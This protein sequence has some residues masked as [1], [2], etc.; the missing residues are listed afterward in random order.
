MVPRGVRNA[1]PGNI[2]RSAIAWQGE[3]PRQPDPDFVTFT[4]PE[5]GL[6]AIARILTTYQASGFTT[7]RQ[8]ISRWAPVN[9]NDTSAYID[10]VT[11][12]VGADADEVL[13]VSSPP[14]MEAM[15]RAI[16][17]HE[18]GE[19]PYSDDTYRLALRLAGLI[20]A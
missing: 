18:N 19:Q 9:E 3:A 12:E 7:I 13:D 11:Q 15:V 20:A 1:N 4:G 17:Q 8:I 2:R 5:W 16:V 6:R 10:H 14:V